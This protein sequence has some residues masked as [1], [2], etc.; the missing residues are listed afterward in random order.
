MRDFSH[1][2]EMF[3]SLVA[4]FSAHVVFLIH[5]LEI[6]SFFTLNKYMKQLL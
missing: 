3:L 2:K 5:L 4:I 1:Q 6:T